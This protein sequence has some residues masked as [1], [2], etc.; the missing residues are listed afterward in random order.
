MGKKIATILIDLTA[1][2]VTVWRNGV[3]LKLLRII[4]CK[5]LSQLLNNLLSDRLFVIYINNAKSK[6]RH[7]NNGLPQG[8]VLAPLL[9]YLYINDIPETIYLKCLYM[10]MISAYRAR[11]RDW[12]NVSK[13]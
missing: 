11:K 1:A 4:A 13:Y 9:F 12:I 2:Y 3:L 5:T 6:K 8:S 7:L 10:Q